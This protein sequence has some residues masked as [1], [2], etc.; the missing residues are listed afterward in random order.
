MY[1]DDQAVRENLMSDIIAKYNLAPSQITKD[2]GINVDTRNR[3]R[4]K[5]IFREFGFPAKRLIGKDAMNGIF[6]MI[7]H[8]D[9]D[10]EW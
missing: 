9:G 7:Q 1:V 2:T 8:S 3:H 5:E 10:K 4:L 6:L